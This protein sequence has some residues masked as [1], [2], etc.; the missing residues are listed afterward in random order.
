MPVLAGL[1]VVSAWVVY[2]LIRAVLDLVAPVEVTGTVLRVMP[3][4][5][6]GHAQGAALAAAQVD[7]PWLRWLTRRRGRPMLSE[8]GFSIGFFAVVDDGRHDR[9]RA[10]SLPPRLRPASAPSG[11]RAT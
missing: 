9:I 5:T 3:A 8:D 2:R 6:F 7:R 10:W 4:G 1:A 11:A